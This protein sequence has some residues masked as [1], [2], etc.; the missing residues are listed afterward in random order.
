[1]NNEEVIS[2]PKC[3]SNKVRVNPFLKYILIAAVLFIW[4]PVLGW[5]TGPFLLI[6]AL[7]AWIVKKYK[8][9]QTMKCQECKH[10]FTVD[11]NKF[12]KYKASL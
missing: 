3:R 4:I 8:K 9:I 11:W 12:N 7:A 10:P 6:V 1:M 5:I 2:C